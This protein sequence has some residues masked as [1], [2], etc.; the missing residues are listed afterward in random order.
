MH[1][2]VDDCIAM[3]K[4]A[5]SLI[6]CRLCLLTSNLKWNY[7]TNL[8]GGK[9]EPLQVGRAAIT[10]SGLHVVVGSYWWS[11]DAT[12]ALRWQV[13]WRTIVD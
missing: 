4:L 10:F 9:Q 11:S 2:R 8:I 13:R 3:E 12:S 1:L 5:H 7:H 6:S